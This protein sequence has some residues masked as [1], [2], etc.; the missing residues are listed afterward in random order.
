MVEKTKNKIVQAVLKE[1][2]N[3]KEKEDL[4]EELGLVKNIKDK[5]ERLIKSVALAREASRRAINIEPYPVQVLAAVKMY[6]GYI[7]EMKTGEGKTFVSPM[8]A[9]A[10]V[11]D[12]QRVHVLTVN[13]YLV[14]RDYNLLFPD[15]TR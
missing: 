8:T 9:F 1:C 2:Q 11:L 12:G 14:E 5:K 13:D 15:T 10:K 7:I 6:Q 4:T 3:L